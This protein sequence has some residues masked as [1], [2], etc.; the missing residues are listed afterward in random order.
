MSRQ[1][2]VKAGFQKAYHRLSAA[3]QHLVDAALQR[4]QR[5]VAIREAPVG[6]GLKHLGGRTYEFRVGLALR[7][8]YVLTDEQIVLALLGTHDDVRRFLKRQ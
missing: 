7:C 4:F 5:Y 1:I 6:L 2:I 3:E 8:V